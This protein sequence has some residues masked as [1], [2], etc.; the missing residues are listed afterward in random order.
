MYVLGR[1]IFRAPLF[2]V[3]AWISSFFFAHVYIFEQ[4]VWM[5]ITRAKLGMLLIHAGAT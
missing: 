2:F 3:C 1:P 4:G 5:S